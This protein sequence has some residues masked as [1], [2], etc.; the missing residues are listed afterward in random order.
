VDLLTM[1]ID[2]RP[3]APVALLCAVMADS[4]ETLSAA[5]ER[6]A[7]GLGPIR[8]ASAVYPFDFTSYYQK[9]MGQGLI[10]QL[11]CL[12]EPVDP[13]ELP[14]TKLRAMALEREMSRVQGAQVLRRANL[15]PGLLSTESLVLAT[16]KHSGHRIC[17]APGLYAEVTLLFQRGK[18]RPFEWTYPD[19]R[20]D[21]V[22]E[23]LQETRAWLMAQRR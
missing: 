14:Q 6:L 11:F 2:L 9:E 13:S 8:A 15:D 12:A 3:A 21:L 10:K 7:A 4:E 22:Q 16:T 19:Y 23:F 5:R 18:Y 17:I 20:T 1:P